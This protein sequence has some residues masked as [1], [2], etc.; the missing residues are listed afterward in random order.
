MLRVCANL[1]IVASSGEANNPGTLGAGHKIIMTGYDTHPLWVAP[2]MIDIY[3][4]AGRHAARCTAAASSVATPSCLFGHIIVSRPCTQNIVPTWRGAPLGAT[5]CFVCHRR[6]T[7]EINTPGLELV[8]QPIPPPAK[9]TG[10]C[11]LGCKYSTSKDHRSR[12]L[13]YAVPS[14]YTWRGAQAGDTLCYAHW[15]SMHRRGDAEL[16]STDTH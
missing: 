16:D 12:P 6:L 7:T 10:P 5:L 11:T 8:T 3:S 4:Q 1:H 14:L 2:V 15:A 9:L 13:W